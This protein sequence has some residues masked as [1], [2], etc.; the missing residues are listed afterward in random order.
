MCAVLMVGGTYSLVA[1]YPWVLSRA[2]VYMHACCLQRFLL[3]G[4]LSW[5][6]RRGLHIPVPDRLWQ[7]MKMN[8]M[9]TTN[10][11]PNSTARQTVLKIPSSC[12]VR[13]SSKMELKK[14]LIFCSMLPPGQAVC[15]APCT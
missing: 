14:E 8:A 4:T 11:R 1:G 10:G 12:L 3:S 7:Q 13:M 9:R 6:G 15:A 5:W 2:C